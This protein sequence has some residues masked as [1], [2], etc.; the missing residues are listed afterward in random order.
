[1]STKVLQSSCT[2]INTLSVLPAT[3][4]L[5]GTLTASARGDKEIGELTEA[6]EKPFSEIPGKLQL[7]ERNS[8]VLYI[9]VIVRAVVHG[10]TCVYIILIVHKSILY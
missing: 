5:L 7:P 2:V 9:I 8:V 3:T 1:M 6:V 4:K 10:V